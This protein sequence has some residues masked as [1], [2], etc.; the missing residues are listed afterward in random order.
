MTA[1]VPVAVVSLERTKL[2]RRGRL[3]ELWTLGWNVLEALVAIVAGSLAGSTALVGFGVDSVIESLSGAAMLWRLSGGDGGQCRERSAQRLVGASLL[4]LAGYV[5]W[6]S[7][8]SLWLAERPEVSYVGV[9]LA[10]LSVL[11]MPLLARAKR[12]V[13]AGLAS[14]A[15]KADSVQT[16]ICGYLSGIL[17]LGLGLNALAGWWWADPIAALCMVPLI[18][19]E[20]IRA[21]RGQPCA[22]HAG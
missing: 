14:G 10:V 13:A 18:L 20:G 8:R 4:V 11:V 12:R 15:M 3:L 19:W 6:E 17:L 21:L 22:C 5:A 9:G 2:I 1:T 7:G 16:E